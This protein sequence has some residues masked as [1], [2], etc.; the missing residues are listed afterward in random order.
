MADI[1]DQIVSV[2]VGNSTTYIDCKGQLYSVYMNS[3]VTGSLSIA[4]SGNV[5]QTVLKVNDLSM[6]YFPSIYRNNNAGLT[7][8][9]TTFGGIMND[10]F[11][12]DSLAITCSGIA[13]AVVLTLRY[14]KV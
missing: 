10:V 1:N 3:S 13:S 9:G 7:M 2:A 5:S 12:N 8:S 4:T 14:I 6:R 11:L